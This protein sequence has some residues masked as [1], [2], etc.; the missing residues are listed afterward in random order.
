MDDYQSPVQP[1]ESAAVIAGRPSIDQGETFAEKVL[2]LS[3]SSSINR[4]DDQVIG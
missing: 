1:K 2:S 4:Q 3:H